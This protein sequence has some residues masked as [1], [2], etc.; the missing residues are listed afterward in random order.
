M[1]DCQGIRLF[2]FFLAAADYN[3]AVSVHCLRPSLFSNLVKAA[4]I[5]GIK[6]LLAEGPESRKEVDQSPLEKFLKLGH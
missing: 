1:Q 2:E 3:L 5:S 4:W 6:S